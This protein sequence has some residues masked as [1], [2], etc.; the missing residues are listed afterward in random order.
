MGPQ[1]L[2]AD[3]AV[4]ANLRNEHERGLPVRVG[5]GAELDDIA[6]NESIRRQ[7][8]SGPFGFGAGSCEERF[9]K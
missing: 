2:A 8:N 5:S 7:S 9:E 3:A 4:V 6:G 1:D